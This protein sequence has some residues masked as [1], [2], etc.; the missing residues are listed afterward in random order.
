MLPLLQ[1]STLI[2]NTKK[3]NSSFNIYR[4]QLFSKK[5]QIIKFC[6]LNLNHYRYMSLS[7][8]KRQHISNNNIHTRNNTNLT[9]SN[10]KMPIVAEEESIPL[11][12]SIDVG[13]TSSRVILFN[14]LGQE[15][16][17]HQIEYSTSASEQNYTPAG[18]RRHSEE[19]KANT[20]DEVKLTTN[21][22]INIKEE[23]E[24]IE[25]NEKHSPI[26]SSVGFK[27]EESPYLT[28]EDLVKNH[29]VGPTLRFP[30][31]GWV[32]CNPTS[33]L[34]NVLECLG[35]VL[36]SLHNTNESRIRHDLKP[37][38][39]HCIGIANMRETT[40]V[41]SKKTGLPIVDYGIVWN[42]TRNA[43]IVNRKKE[44]TDPTLQNKLT[45]KTGLPL[46]ST[47]FSCSKLRWFLDN[48]P[49]VKH[50]YLNSDLMF[51]T[52]DT[53]L[54]YHLTST[55]NFVSDVT[56]ASRTG[57][58]N[59]DTL[60]YDPE[61]LKYW[62]IDPTKVSL[63]KIVSSAEYYG[64]F[65][66][67][68]FCEAILP[69]TI[70]QLLSNFASL[71]VPI[72]GC[73][74]DQSASLVGQ[75]AYKRGAAK[76]TYGTGCF[77]LYNTGTE[78]LISRH[79]TLT[80][81]G[82][83]FP[84][85]ENEFNINKPHFA[86]EGSVAVA[87]SV[88]QWLR[89]NLRLVARAEDVGPL[90][91]LVPDSGGVVF[92]PAFSGLFAPYWDPDCRATIMG[93]SQFTTASHIA[94]AAVEGVCFQA[95]A[96]L[97]AMS[98]DAYSESRPNTHDGKIPKDIDLLEDVDTC[99]YE[100]SVFSTLSVDGGMSRSDEVMQIQADILG[101]CIKVR[102]SPIAESTALGAAI[103]ANMGFKEENERPM[104]KNLHDCKKW[105]F[106]NGVDKS[107][108]IPRE[109]HPNL[110]VFTSRS[111][112]TIRRKHWKLWETAVARSTGWLKAVEDA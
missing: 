10:I 9:Q 42:D 60:N 31:P 79:G 59:L 43:S 100:K 3:I 1:R 102:R 44:T 13:T 72:N 97:K 48:V 74:G 17:K 11:I 55:N 56:N 84:Y 106:F 111:K 68:K 46:Y 38:R 93:I 47:Y 29:T 87:G 49:E 19:L 67:P 8:N 70:K 109:Q 2:K 20:L 15:V 4:T 62:D 39:I 52:V 33:I 112:D 40:I 69:P 28:I 76:C 18:R 101:P 22:N 107:E 25:K 65:N 103:A 89:D 30:K 71:K 88:V 80:T 27:I 41:W 45:E 26:F 110:K 50:S 36:Q 78:K 32:E 24:E 34:I 77:L 104:W 86:L 83:W 73:L 94:R 81:L 12:V 7:I 64:D 105:V 63:P 6:S 54:I 16:S 85:L 96:I 57:F 51:G 14:K 21:N 5:F 61:L 108:T 90:A 98:S 92:V 91:S 23:E 99:T 35:A 53:W 75:M 58:M 66:V 37:Y 82:F 95:R